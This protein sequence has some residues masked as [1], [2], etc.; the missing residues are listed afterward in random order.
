MNKIFTLIAAAV[1][2]TPCSIQAE[3][4][5]EALA[6]TVFEKYVSDPAENARVEE[7]PGSYHIGFPSVSTLSDSTRGM[8][9]TNTTTGKTHPAIGSLASDIAGATYGE[10]GVMIIF[11]FEPITEIGYYTMTFPAGA[12]TVGTEK[13]PAFETHF[14]IGMDPLTEV[15]ALEAESDTVTVSDLNGRILLENAPAEALDGLDAGIYIV[16]GRTTMLRR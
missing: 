13:S 8:V 12:F 7:L 16:N 11:G 9:L 15:T 5:E 14:Y 10:N 4:P 2:A 3:N 1:I 6:G